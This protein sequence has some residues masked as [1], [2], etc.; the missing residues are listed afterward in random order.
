MKEVSCRG[1]I[2][3]DNYKKRLFVR[4]QQII[5]ISAYYKLENMS[6]FVL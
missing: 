1:N 5:K 4:V 2:T 3:I 6:F